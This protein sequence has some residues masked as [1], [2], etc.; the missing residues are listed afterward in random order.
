MY[1]LV[2]DE[3]FFCEAH[4]SCLDDSSFVSDMSM[5]CLR[6]H[7]GSVTWTGTTCIV[8]TDLSPVLH[9]ISMVFYDVCLVS[10]HGY[11]PTIVF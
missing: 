5:G 4:W 8:S 9:P 6:M 3:Q 11:Y 2:G 10:L 1:S 7:R